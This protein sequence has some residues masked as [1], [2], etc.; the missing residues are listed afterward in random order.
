MGDPYQ[1]KNFERVLM[2]K[3]LQLM[4]RNPLEYIANFRRKVF[5]ELPQLELLKPSLARDN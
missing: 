4:D 3:Q 5:N 2:R 1:M